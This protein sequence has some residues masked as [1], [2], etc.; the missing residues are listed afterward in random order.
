VGLGFKLQQKTLPQYLHIVA[1]LRVGSAVAYT[2][3]L[4]VFTVRS[5][6]GNKNIRLYILPPMGNGRCVLGHQSVTAGGRCLVKC[7]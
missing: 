3:V 7:R 6:T 4:S 1:T 2:V 5:A